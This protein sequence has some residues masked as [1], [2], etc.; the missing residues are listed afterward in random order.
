MN[1]FRM[2]R[3]PY[4]KRNYGYDSKVCF[5]RHLH[6]SPQLIKRDF[7]STF[8]QAYNFDNVSWSFLNRINNKDRQQRLSRLR[9]YP[10]RQEQS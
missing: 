4:E 5:N 10:E 2:L 7:R 1:L 9:H 6:T 3:T 8:S